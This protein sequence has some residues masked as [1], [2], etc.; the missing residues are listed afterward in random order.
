MK[1]N[2]LTIKEYAIAEE[3]TTSA[4]YN[5]VRRGKLKKIIKYGITFVYSGNDKTI[6]KPIKNKA[7]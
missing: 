7:I 4:I 3:V 6:K 2:L 5:R 1:N